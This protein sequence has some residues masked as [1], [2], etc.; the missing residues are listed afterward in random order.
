MAPGPRLSIPVVDHPP[1]EWRRVADACKVYS[2]FLAT[3]LPGQSF[4]P[5]KK[6]TAR[7]ESPA[8]GGRHPLQGGTL[9]GSILMV[10]P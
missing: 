8:K 2:H 5:S 7:R 6:A 4:E 1:S 10:I 9:V 3:Y